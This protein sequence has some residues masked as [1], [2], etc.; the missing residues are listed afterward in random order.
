MLDGPTVA[1]ALRDS[2]VTHVVWIPDSELGRW[3]QALLAEPSLSLIRVCRE[4]EAVAV[5]AG[6]YL[7]GKRP[8]VMMQCTGFFDAGDAFRNV[9]HDLGLPLFFLVGIRSFYQY[10]DGKSTDTCPVFAQDIVAAW[11]VPHAVRALDHGAWDLRELLMDCFRSQKP[12]VLL[13]AE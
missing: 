11:K 13:Y 7:G 12:F 2:G 6:L 1:A 5:A 9:V 3:E 4:G 10:R 8:V